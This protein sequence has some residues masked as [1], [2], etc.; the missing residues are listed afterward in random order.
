M[1]KACLQNASTAYLKFR[2][3][4]L[5]TGLKSKDIKQL[6]RADKACFLSFKTGQK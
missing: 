1:S 6:L 5:K 3:F 4:P 2:F